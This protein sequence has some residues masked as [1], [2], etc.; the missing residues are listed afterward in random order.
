M[1][2][3]V[4]S[5]CYLFIS[6]NISILTNS[7]HRDYNNCTTDGKAFD[8]PSNIVQAS[9]IGN[10]EEK[11]PSDDDLLQQSEKELVSLQP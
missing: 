2:L 9:R 1:I 5:N 11:I 3:F 8:N 6:H 7:S 10:L 4:A